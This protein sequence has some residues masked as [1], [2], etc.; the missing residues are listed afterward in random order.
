MPL[1]S[2]KFFSPYK[3][4]T[5][6]FKLIAILS[7]FAAISGL[8]ASFQR[9]EARS[10]NILVFGDSL[11]AGYG[12]AATDS[13]PAQ[14]ERALKA[15]GLDV[16]VNNAGVS[17]DTTSGGLS[18]LGWVLSGSQVKWLDLV[19]LELGANDALRGVD[20]KISRDNLRIMLETLKNN[21]IPVLLAGM[22]AP[23]NMGPQYGEE[24][25]SIYPD[26]AKEF[27]VKLYPFFLEGVAGIPALNQADGIHPTRE[28]VD[29]ITGKI[30]PYV[31]PFI[32]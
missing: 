28:G 2:S 27:D 1:P 20:P 4:V 18:R 8:D 25:N 24:F 17:G 3:I 31:L 29:V 22:L 14:L 10:K 12:L 26:L 19:I 13:F 7:L 30:L 32:E 23:P 21:N 15:K 9:A 11:T 5:H 16:V 6:S